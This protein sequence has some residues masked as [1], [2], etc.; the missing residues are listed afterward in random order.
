MPM[1]IATALQRIE[2]LTPTYLS[3]VLKGEGVY[4]L[5]SPAELPEEF[6]AAQ[7]ERTEHYM[8]AEDRTTA[9]TLPGHAPRYI[10]TSYGL[11]IAWVTLDGRTHYTENLGNHFEGARLRAVRR[12]QDAVRA[13][14]PERFGLDADGDASRRVPA[15]FRRDDDGELH[16]V[17]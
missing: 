3:P 14:W 6:R 8:T 1:T 5:S 16:P 7:K 12:H 17:D 9:R 4:V 13:A 10:V 11:P 2:N 15:G